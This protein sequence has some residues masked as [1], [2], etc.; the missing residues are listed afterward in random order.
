MMRSLLVATALASTSLAAHVVGRAAATAPCTADAS[1]RVSLQMDNMLSGG[2]CVCPGTAPTERCPP[3]GTEC[4]VEN[5]TLTNYYKTS[6]D[7]APAPFP[8]IDGCRSIN[9]TT[10]CYGASPAHLV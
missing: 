9:I 3:K 4:G 10:P 2:R 8:G 5:G 7:Y 6:N 1:V